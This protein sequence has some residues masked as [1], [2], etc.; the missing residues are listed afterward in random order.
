MKIFALGHR[1]YVGKDTAARFMISQIRVDYRLEVKKVAFAKY[2]KYVAYSL[3]KHYGLHNPDYYEKN[4][5]FK[6][7]LI[8]ELGLS[9]R[10]L[11]IRFGNDM[12]TYHKDIWVDSAIG[13]VEAD[14]II[15]TDLRYPNEADA[16]LK[17]GAVLIKID[18]EAIPKCCDVADCALEDFT[19][20]HYVIENDTIDNLHKRVT[21]IVKKELD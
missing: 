8:P 7:T 6:E 16:L 14:V 4:P 17:R 9:A 21:G 2:L 13:T 18:R 1:R 12:R 11:W 3:F 10:D 5:I 19:G 20:W 15:I